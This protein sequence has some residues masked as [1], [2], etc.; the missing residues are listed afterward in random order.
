ME[1]MLTFTYGDGRNKSLPVYIDSTM[2]E[3]V[4]QYT[5]YKTGLSGY[6]LVCCTGGELNV[7]TALQ[8]ITLK[9]GDIFFAMDGKHYQY[10]SKEK[11][12]RLKIIAFNGQGAGALVRY[13]DIQDT[14]LYKVQ[15]PY[16]DIGFQRIG[17]NVHMKNF[18]EA[19]LGFQYMLCE[20]ARNKKTLENEKNIEIL[21]RYMERNYCQDIDNQMLADIYGTS[22]SYLCREFKAHYHTSPMTYINNLRIEKARHMLAVSRK[23][24]AV[25][26]RECGFSNAD[27]FCYAFKKSERCTPLQY[28]KKK[29]VFYAIENVFS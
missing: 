18:F 24:V 11:E 19:A 5:K 3:R 16:F 12:C 10:S 9:E 17:R 1:E 26:A 7:K 28:R 6:A 27:Y 22:V 2:F 8:E 4:E 15:L 13:F 20:I 21:K 25:I 23:K 14:K 29:S